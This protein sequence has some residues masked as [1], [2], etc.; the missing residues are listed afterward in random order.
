MGRG[1]SQATRPSVLRLVLCGPSLPADSL[2]GNTRTGQQGR[3]PQ[4]REGVA[5][6]GQLA[7][8]RA[9]GRPTG[10]S[11]PAGRQSGSL[12]TSGPRS[13]QALRAPKGGERKPCL[14]CC[15]PGKHSRK[16]ACHLWPSPWTPDG[17]PVLS[18]LPGL[19]FCLRRGCER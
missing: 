17:W 3:G 6:A 14:A 19:F 2:G 10:D 12:T 1:R 8:V 9:Q 15:H 4:R 18:L 11:S 5:L 7:E 16:T 13:S